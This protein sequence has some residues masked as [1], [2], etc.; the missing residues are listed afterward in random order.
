LRPL[1]R[2]HVRM[3][4]PEGHAEDS[5]TF[6]A[7]PGKHYTSESEEQAIERVVDYLDKKYQY[8]NFKIVKVARGRYN[9]M[10]DGLREREQAEDSDAESILRPEQGGDVPEVQSAEVAGVPRSRDGGDERA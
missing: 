7:P 6:K 2:I 10:Y 1:K 3:I 9:F 8:W 4:P 5:Y